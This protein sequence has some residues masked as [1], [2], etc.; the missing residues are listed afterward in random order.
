[1]TN[2]DTVT[3]GSIGPRSVRD[4]STT[5]SEIFPGVIT[6]YVAGWGLQSMDR[7]PGWH[8]A[9]RGSKADYLRE[10]PKLAAERHWDAVSVGGAP[11]ELM[12]PGLYDDLSAR[13]DVP[14]ATA[15]VSCSAALRTFGIEKALLITGFFEGIDEMLYGYFCHDGIELVWPD[16]K[17][18]ADYTAGSNSDSSVLFD[19]TKR[20]AEENPGVK[21]VYFQGSVNV[22]PIIG[23]VESE[24]GLTVVS[25]TAYQWYILSRLGK[26]FH[27]KGGGRLLEE[28]PALPAER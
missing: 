15:M 25:G 10:I 9:I 8:K 17:P 7:G 11:I 24:L 27:V 6:D 2:S 28:W 5:A 26:K 18:F 1:M 14:V 21:A 13:L 12:N 20:T 22:R 16:S 4:N 23:R 19:L 3:I